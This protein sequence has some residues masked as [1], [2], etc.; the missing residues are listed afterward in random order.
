MTFLVCRRCMPLCQRWVSYH[1]WGRSKSKQIHLLRSLLDCSIIACSHFRGPR[2]LDLRWTCQA[3]HWI[4]TGAQLHATS[5]HLR[6]CDALCISN[7]FYLIRQ[8]LWAIWRNPLWVTV[9]HD[10]DIALNSISFHPSLDLNTPKSYTSIGAS[11]AEWTFWSSWGHWA[12]MHPQ[13]HTAS[14]YILYKHWGSCGTWST[15][16]TWQAFCKLKVWIHRSFAIEDFTLHM[17]QTDIFHAE[18]HILLQDINTSHKSRKNKV[19]RDQ[20]RHELPSV[21]GTCHPSW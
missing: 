16:E 19:Q 15:L 3:R 7:L 21:Q 11:L 1:S 10:K 9:W 13:L 17:L 4:W 12:Q 6:S 14:I 8:K 2:S 20:G 5:S 18:L